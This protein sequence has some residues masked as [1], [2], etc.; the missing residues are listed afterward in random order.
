MRSAVQQK[1][2]KTKKKKQTGVKFVFVKATN[3]PLSLNSLA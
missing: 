2:T 1:K 3:Q